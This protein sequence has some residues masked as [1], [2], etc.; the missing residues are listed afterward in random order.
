[1]KYSVIKKGELLCQTLCINNVFKSVVWLESFNGPSLSAARVHAAAT[2]QGNARESGRQ[3]VG[4][5]GA[6]AT[7]S[8][9]PGKLGLGWSRL[10]QGSAHCIRLRV[11][12][13]RTGMGIFKIF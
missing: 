12:N 5:G 8:S 7:A 10:R 9:R 6:R 13:E 11:S 2:G 4:A 3:G 1:M